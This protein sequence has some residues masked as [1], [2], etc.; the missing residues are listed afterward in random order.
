MNKALVALAVVGVAAF[1][2]TLTLAIIS[3]QNQ[4]P[5]ATPA[6]QAQQPVNKHDLLKLV[7]EERAK[8]GVPALVIDERLNQ[9]AQRKAD[10]MEK[11]DYF[12]HVSPIDGRYGASY[13]NDTGIPCQRVSENIRYNGYGKNTAKDAVLGWYGSELHRVAMLNQKYESTG[14]GIAGS[15]IVQH[16]CE[17]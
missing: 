4:Q 17:P 13:A 16:F 3:L 11:N 5:D 12:D 9:S 1:G 10:D 8:V 6:I 7:N 2:S 14:F 15:R